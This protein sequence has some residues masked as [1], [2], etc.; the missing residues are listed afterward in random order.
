MSCLSLQPASVLF[1]S[2]TVLQIVLHPQR[3]M[4]K[5]L[6]LRSADTVACPQRY[7]GTFAIAIPRSEQ[8]RYILCLTCVYFVIF[9]LL[10][11]GIRRE[12]CFDEKFVIIRC[13]FPR[14]WV[15][16][17]LY[18]TSAA[19]AHPVL[20]YINS[21]LFL[22]RYSRPPTRDTNRAKAIVPE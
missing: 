3:V 2:V 15:S 13:E 10:N 9:I 14:V 16:V 8:Y 5:Q 1:K 18:H 7:R 4:R 17:F 12:F 20:L 21:K 6:P 19:M 11:V 22:L